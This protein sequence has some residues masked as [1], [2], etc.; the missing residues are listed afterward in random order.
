[1][2]S[3]CTGPQEEWER[4]TWDGGRNGDAWG[5]PRGEAE[6]ER[7][8]TAKEMTTVKEERRRRGHNEQVRSDGDRGERRGYGQ[9]ERE[10]ESEG[11]GGRSE[12][13]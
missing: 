10:A 1:M 2:A 6:T 4:R 3:G 12:G 5:R 13:D 11:W 9:G 7:R 8:T